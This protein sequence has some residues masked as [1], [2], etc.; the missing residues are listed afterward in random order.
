MAGLAPTEGRWPYQATMNLAKFAEAEPN[1]TLECHR[2]KEDNHR[3]ATAAHQP[4]PNSGMSTLMKTIGVSTTAQHLPKPNPGTPTGLWCVNQSQTPSETK[5]WNAHWTHEDTWCARKAKAAH[6]S[7]PKP[8]ICRS[9]SRVPGSSK[10]NPN[11]RQEKRMH[12]M[13]GKIQLA[14]RCKV[15]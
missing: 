9:R 6:L 1:R 4:K 14:R 11:A 15:R 5:P 2:T 3:K 8:H 13:A 7:K 10:R 12:G